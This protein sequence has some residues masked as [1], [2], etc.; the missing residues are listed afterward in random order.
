MGDRSPAPSPAS[1]QL[2]ITGL[3]PGVYG[4]IPTATRA[5][6]EDPSVTVILRTI[7]HPAAEELAVRRAVTTCDDLYEAEE[8]FDDVYE[9]IADRVVHALSDG[10]VIY[11]VPGSPLVGELAV[12]K[13]L[14]RVAEA[15]MVPAESFLDAIL[16]EVAYDP[17]DRGLRVINGHELP[18]PLALDAPTV[19]G[20]LDRAEVLADVAAAVSRVLPDGAQVTLCV[21]LG[22]PH[23]QVSRLPIDQVPPERA[24]LRTSLFIDTEPAGLIGL[25]G[26]SRRL[27]AECPWDREQTHQSLVRHLIEEVYELV[28]AIGDLPEVGEETDHVAYAHLEEELGDV[29]LQVLFHAAIAHENGAFGIDDVATRLQ[30]KL[31]RRHPHV[32]GDVEVAGSD[33]VAENWERIKT[34]ERAD[35]RASLLDGVP[36]GLPALDMA[37]KLQ[38]RAATIGFDWSGPGEVLPVLRDE[39]EELARALEEGHAAAAEEAGDVVFTVVNLLR[40]LGVPTE[41]AVRQATQRFQRRFRAMEAQGPLDGLDSDDLERRWKDAKRTVG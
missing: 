40:H 41:L 37:E 28:D 39:V 13:L 15:E 33:E 7:R 23:P 3:G 16:T 22:G 21:D 6:L 29:L 18:D 10:P 36:S 14:E 32:F 2:T 11:A 5:R 31:V 38:R 27:R 1:H 26:V 25:V 8:R 20:Q 35:E 9:A 17:L 12:R 30:E 4:R 34:Q 24:G 19:I